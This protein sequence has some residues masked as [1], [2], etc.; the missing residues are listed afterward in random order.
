MNYNRSDWWKLT[1]GS[2]VMNTTS[3]RVYQTEE[4]ERGSEEAANNLG[5]LRI[6]LLFGERD[7]NSLVRSKFGE[8]GRGRGVSSSIK[9]ITVP[10]TSFLNIPTCRVRIPR[11]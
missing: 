4:G 1:N 8:L 5:R 9:K 2:D 6:R 10:R 11:S 3:N 7:R